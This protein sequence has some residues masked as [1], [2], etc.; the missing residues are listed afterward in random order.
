[1]RRSLQSG[2]WFHPDGFPIAI[3]RPNHQEAFERP[4]HEFSEI[5]IVTGGHGFHRLGKESWPLIAGDILII[6]G[7][8]VRQY[9]V[10]SDLRL[11]RIIFQPAKLNCDMG[12]LGALPGYH[13]LFQCEPGAARQP[14]RSRFHL[15]PRDFSVVTEFVDELDRE[16][17]A[18]APGF[19]FLATAWFMQIVGYICRCY[20]RKQNHDNRALLRIA[21]AIAPIETDS[22]QL[23][24]LDGMARMAQ[25]SRRSFTR[26]FQAAVGTSPIAYLIQV[27]LNRAA[28]LLR[29]DQQSITEIAFRVGFRDSNYFTRQFRN[30]FGM[31]PRTYRQRH[32]RFAPVP[33]NGA[34][35]IWDGGALSS[36][37]SRGAPVVVRK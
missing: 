13:A 23:M 25:M 7:R 14:F 19:A 26:A 22:A 20:G 21:E 18:R 5:V 30:L 33:E 27:R 16:L 37:S 2:E 11:I 36:L 12:G 34:E 31:A 15:G 8:R 32:T 24:N 29:Q 35:K 1:M 9:C 3:D 17:Q 6:E 10:T 4:R 28:A